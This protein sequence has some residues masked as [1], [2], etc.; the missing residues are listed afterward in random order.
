MF[1]EYIFSKG[2]SESRINIP[3]TPTLYLKVT[4]CV[5]LWQRDSKEGKGIAS[6]HEDRE[7]GRCKGKVEVMGP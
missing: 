6:I 3:V 1:K 5:T 4:L 2:T 7:V